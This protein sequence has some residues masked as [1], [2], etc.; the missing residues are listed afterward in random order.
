MTTPNNLQPMM[1]GVVG[2]SSGVTDEKL[3]KLIQSTKDS[4]KSKQIIEWTRT[5][6]QRCK[7]VRQTI[8]RQW[9]INMAFYLGKQNIAIQANAG[10]SPVTG[11]RLYTPRVPYYRS[12]PVFNR[13]RPIVRKELAKLTAQKPSATIVPAT[14]EDV[15]LAAATAGEQLWD[16]IY[17]RKKI[18]A[19]HR[20]T[21]LWTLTCGN[22]FMKTYWD[23]NATDEQGQPGD[24]CYENVTPFHL[25]VP[26]M[27]CEDI[28]DQPFVIQIRTVTPEWVKLNLKL[29]VQPDVVEAD[30]ILNDSFLNLVGATEFRKNAVLMYEVWAKPNNISFMPNGGMF[31]IVGNNVVQFVEGQVYQHGQ[32]PYVKFD[33]IPTGRFYCDSIINDLI[34]VQKEYNRTRGQ[35]IESK[36]RM[37]HLQLLAAKGSIKANKITTEPGQVI[38]YELGYPAPTPMPLQGLPSYIVQ[39]I[40]RLLSDFDDISG[41]HDVSKGQT[42]PGVT[43]ATAISYLQEQDDSVLSHTFNSIEEGFEK[44]AFQTLNYIKQFWD[45][46][47]TVRVTGRDNQFNVMA[48][49]GTDLRNNTDIRIEA[50]SALPTSKAAKQALIMD[51]MQLGFI[52]PQKGLELIDMGGVQ[53]LYEQMQVDSA[54]AQRENMR[55]MAITQDIMDQYAQSFMGVNPMDGSAQLVDPNTQ[56]PL[57]DQSGQPT[58]PPL[59]VPVNSYDNH[60]VHIQVHNNFRKSQQYDNASPEVKQLFEQHVNQHMMAIGMMS[61]MPDPGSGMMNQQI[62]MDQNNQDPNASAMPSAPGAPGMQQNNPAPGPVAAQGP[63]GIGVQMPPGSTPPGMGGM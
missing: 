14:G 6:Y 7:T 55:M 41:Q 33:H 63:G 15:D 20:E 2:N 21:M 48:F 49:K 17:R 45:L 52:D 27:M 26:D 51:L 37:G 8:E 50:G 44:I 13:I 12:R 19:T 46:P 31:T 35:I 62:P 47:R 53:R 42:P 25:F 36:N 54:Q 60:Q 59:I 5:S 57:Q 18:K 22:G 28:E 58:E 38:E 24:F 43:A 39:E 10:S 32:Y 3:Q 40:D 4:E 9:Y 56:G 16:S 1:T 30:D 23:P 29:D 34:S 11:I 61:G